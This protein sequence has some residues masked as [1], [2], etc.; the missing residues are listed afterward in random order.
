LLHTM[1]VLTDEDQISFCHFESKD[2]VRH[3]LVQ[4]IV[5]AYEQFES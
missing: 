5:L 3:K 4:C 2:V 1:K